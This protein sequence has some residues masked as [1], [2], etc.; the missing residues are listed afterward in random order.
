MPRAKSSAY[1][2]QRLELGVKEREMME[3]FIYL[4][5]IPNVLMGTAGI[6]A[7]GGIGIAGFA[8]YQ[9]LSETAFDDIWP[10]LKEYI[11]EQLG[12]GSRP[13]NPPAPP[14]PGQWNDPEHPDYERQYGGGQGGAFGGPAPGN[15]NF[16]ERDAN[17]EWVRIPG[18]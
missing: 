18:T 13:V 4:N 10:S 6:I 9:F 12:L 1:L 11:L 5:A 17:G 15:P 7:A 16:W 8:A 14:T 2:T 3:Q